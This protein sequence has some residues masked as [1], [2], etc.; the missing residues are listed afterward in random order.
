MASSFS[1]EFIF[2]NLNDGLRSE[3][4]SFWALNQTAFQAELQGFRSGLAQNRLLEPKGLMKRQP[5]A[6]A[7]DQ[8]GE[9]IGIVFLALRELNAGLDLG[10]HAYFQRMYILPRERNARLAN[11]LY[12]AFLAGFD[13]ALELRDHRA[14]YLLSE[15]I[16]VGL[17]SASMRRYFARHGFRILGSNQFGSEVWIRKLETLFVF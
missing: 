17:Q 13:N 14:R 5:A 9:I 2:G 3:L 6:I 16:N 10:T 8:G 4:R 7:R 11:Q 15:N 12:L 1:I